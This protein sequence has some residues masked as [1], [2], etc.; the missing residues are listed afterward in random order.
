M[1]T[2]ATCIF[3]KSRAESRPRIQEAMAAAKAGEWRCLL[4]GVPLAMMGAFIPTLDFDMAAPPWRSMS[5]CRAF[6]ESL[7]LLSGRATEAP[8]R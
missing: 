2:E 8:V 1:R 6:E 3:L 4:C 7:R 5:C